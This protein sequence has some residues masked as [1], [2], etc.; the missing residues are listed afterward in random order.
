[1]DRNGRAC[2][3]ALPATDRTWERVES[4]LLSGLVAMLGVQGQRYL[5]AGEIL[6]RPAIIIR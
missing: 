4:S 5:T 6:E 3:A 1:M 2:R